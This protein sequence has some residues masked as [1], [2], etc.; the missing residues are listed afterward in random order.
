MLTCPSCGEVVERGWHHC[1]SCGASLPVRRKPWERVDWRSPVT[2]VAVAVVVLLLAGVSL[3]GTERRFEKAG[4]DLDDTRL[5]LREQRDLVTA[6]RGELSQRVVER[7]ALRKELDTTKG[8]LSDA[9]RSVESQG[10]Q[11]ETFKACLNAIN[12]IVV[13]LDEGD[14]RAA[15]EAADRADR[16]CA[17]AAAFL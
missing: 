10:K 12:D 14:E 15:R 4:R 11:L 9:Q 6:L 17:E 3:A 7:D 13:A 8:S 16:H 5:T 1:A 2:L